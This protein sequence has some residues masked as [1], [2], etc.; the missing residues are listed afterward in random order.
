MQVRL[1]R[2]GPTKCAR[3][4]PLSNLRGSAVRA[5]QVAGVYNRCGRRAT[6]KTWPRLH[7]VA[8][9]LC[10]LPPGALALKVCQLRRTRFGATIDG[11]PL[12]IP[13]A[14]KSLEGR[15]T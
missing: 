10:L 4:E 14:L 7:V 9:P 11:I 8:P 2:T 15:I 6:P 1:R 12:R 5:W 3:I 13:H